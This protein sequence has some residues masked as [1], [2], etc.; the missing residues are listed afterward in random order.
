MFAIFK[1]GGP[2]M[3]PLL[4]CSVIV[5]GVIIERGVFWLQ[6]E[7]RRDRQLVAVRLVDNG[8]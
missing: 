5:L 2:V 8:G 4:A 7:V 6:I 1:S 3:Y